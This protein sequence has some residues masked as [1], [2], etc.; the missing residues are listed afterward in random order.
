MKRFSLWC[1]RAIF[2]TLVSVGGCACAWIRGTPRGPGDFGQGRSE[3]YGNS[4]QLWVWWATVCPL[5]YR[6]HQY[7]AVDLMRICWCT[8]LYVGY[9]W[10]VGQQTSF[11]VHNSQITFDFSNSSTIFILVCMQLFRSPHPLMWWC[12]IGLSHATRL[13]Y[14]IKCSQCHAWLN[15]ECNIP[16]MIWFVRNH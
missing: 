9:Y 11:S 13:G 3:L 15:C 10:Q 7:L 6:N 8:P 12:K 14:R 5:F 1:A 16:L 2:C 4:W